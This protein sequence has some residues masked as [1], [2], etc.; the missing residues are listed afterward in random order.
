MLSVRRLFALAKTGRHHGGLGKR[1]TQARLAGN[2]E[3]N[4]ERFRDTRGGKQALAW[5]AGQGLAPGEVG[6]AP[7]EGGESSLAIARMEAL[8]WWMSEQGEDVGFVDM[9]RKN[10][11]AM[12]LG[13]LLPEY[14]G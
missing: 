12:L 2:G 8:R 4:D 5:H 3:G 11:Q 1:R 10:D 6:R 14:R 13:R 7:W 9:S